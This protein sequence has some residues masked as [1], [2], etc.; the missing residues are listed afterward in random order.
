MGGFKRNVTFSA[1]D[2]YHITRHRKDITKEMLAKVMLLFRTGVFT[3]PNPLHIYPASKVEDAFR[4][5][6]GGQHMGRIVVVPQDREV[7]P[8]T[9]RQNPIWKFSADA[10]YLIVGGFGGLGRAILPWMARKGARHIVVLSRKGPISIAA[11]EVISM[12]QDQGVMIHAPPCDV[13][14]QEEL[15]SALRVVRST[16]PPIK[17]CINAAMLLQVS[18]ATVS[19]DK[20]LGLTLSGHVLCQ[21]VTI[22]M[23]R[24]GRFQAQIIHTFICTFTGRYGLLPSLL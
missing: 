4:Y 1:I 12:L 8:K 14:S 20:A 11:Q 3:V 7:V 15:E 23:A 22:S 13:S 5:M 6:Q 18:E 10:S 19:M 17:G 21:H 24:Y 16:M 9:L 2:F